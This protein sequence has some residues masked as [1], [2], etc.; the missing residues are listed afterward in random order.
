MSDH[1]QTRKA[2]ADARPIIAMEEKEY[3]KRMKK[4]SQKKSQQRKKKTKSTPSAPKSNKKIRIEGG[5]YELNSGN[6]IPGT[7]GGRGNW[8]RRISG[9][10]VPSGDEGI[11]A[12]LAGSGLKD[13]VYWMHSLNLGN[14][15]IV[16]V[17]SGK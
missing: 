8:I 1:K 4:Q 9:R 11:V 3:T 16:A 5:G 2:V 14:S 10:S 15:C 12:A 13:E 17:D 7:S 6:W